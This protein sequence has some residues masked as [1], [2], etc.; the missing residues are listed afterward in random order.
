MKCSY[1]IVPEGFEVLTAVKMSVLVFWIIKPCGIIRRYQ[2]FG[3]TYCPIYR[4]QA[5]HQHLSLKVKA[6]RELRHT[7]DLLGWTAMSVALHNF[8][9]RPLGC[10]A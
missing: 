10:V 6:E 5:Q 1:N 4:D 7:S 3:E 2:C 8:A 9:V